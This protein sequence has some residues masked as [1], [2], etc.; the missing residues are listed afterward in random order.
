M[1][2][3]IYDD[4]ISLGEAAASHVLSLIAQAIAAQGEARV[5][6]ATGASQYEFLAALVRRKAAV[7]WTKVTAFH[8]DE[9]LGLPEDHPASFRRYLRERLFNLLP[10]REVNLLDGMAPNAKVEAARY[11]ARL[12]TG[13]IDLACIGIGENGHL[14]FNDPPADFDT[15]K[16]VHIVT[17]DDACRRQ[18]VGE[19][20]FPTMADV[21]AQALSLSIPAILAARAV[22]CVAPDQRKAAAVQCALEGPVTPICPASALQ[23]HPN[24]MLFLDRASASGLKHGSLT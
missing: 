21:P 22:S 16:W 18:Q 9:Y 3:S 24:T 17:L 10:F 20:H 11:A 5:I 15:P 13:P 8:L 19:G 23:R 1:G 14:A 2:V 7:D 12:V 6:F 4:K